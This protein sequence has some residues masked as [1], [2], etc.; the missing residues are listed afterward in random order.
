[1][2]KLA[3]LVLTGLF[4]LVF[5]ADWV[6]ELQWRHNLVAKGYGRFLDTT[7]V[8]LERQVRSTVL[9]GSS[10]AAADEALQNEGLN[11]SYDPQSRAIYAGARY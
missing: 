6:L 3:V 4:C 1:M 2:W 11:S 7:A 8:A 10:R 5:L 9:I